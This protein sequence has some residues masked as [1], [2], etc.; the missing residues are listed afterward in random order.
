MGMPVEKR[1][2]ILWAAAILGLLAVLLLPLAASAVTVGPAKLQISIDP[3]QTATGF[4]FL[5]NEES[6]ARVFYPSI[7][8]FSVDSGG[9]KAF[10]DDNATIAKWMQL[11]ESIALESQDEAQV[12]FTMVVP[13]DAAPGG[14][15]AVIWWSTSPPKGDGQ[16]AIVTRAGILVYVRVSGNIVE[17]G[18]INAFS[19]DKR[20]VWSPTISF[21]VDFVNEG[22]VALTPQGDLRIVNVFGAVKEVL[23]VN[24][25]GRII[26]PG[27]NGGLGIAWKGSGFFFGL[28]K[29]DLDLTFGETN[30][31]AEAHWWFVVISP[32]AGLIVLLAILLL[33]VAP[34]LLRRYNRWVIERAKQQ[35]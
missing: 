10:T 20:F 3:G 23:P 5:K 26:L 27:S 21:A 29:A 7:Q 17:K 8:R 28:Y 19:G 18:H 6:K 30:L 13:E 22:N 9:Q 1:R 15:F 31:T 33:F 12:P 11:P 14:H 34:P 2:S 32:L 16:V 35:V 25:H 4:L 24:P